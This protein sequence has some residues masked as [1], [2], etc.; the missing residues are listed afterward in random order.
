MVFGIQTSVD[1]FRAT[2]PASSKHA[3]KSTQLFD[4]SES[5]KAHE[6]RLWRF[7][8]EKEPELILDSNVLDS[9]LS[10]S[11]EHVDAGS[12]YQIS[13]HAQISQ[14]FA[15]DLTVMF[16]KTVK[17]GDIDRQ[18][19]TALR[20]LPTF[21]SFCESEM[22]REYVDEKV[23]AQL[24]QDLLTDNNT[25]FQY[26]R[27]SIK[28][29]QTD[30]KTLS[31][32]LLFFQDCHGLLFRKTLSW[33]RSERKQLLSGKIKAVRSIRTLLDGITLANR[34]Q[35][36]QLLEE[37]EAQ[38]E[39]FEKRDLLQLRD[40]MTKTKAGSR[41]S[42][43]STM[44]ALINQLLDR[45][46]RD[47]TSR[48]PIEIFLR[49]SKISVSAFWPK[50]RETLENGLGNPEVYLDNRLQV[51]DGTEA[52]NEQV[53]RPIHGNP[54]CM[55]YQ[56]LQESGALVNV[57]DWWEAFKALLEDSELEDQHM[58][59]LFQRGLAELQFLGLIR[60]S[61]RKADH[62]H[63]TTWAGIA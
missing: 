52:I 42:I 43:D 1:N 46:S 18:V 25:L 9:A 61:R 22:N 33:D 26:T 35:L 5:Q 37:F 44:K 54:T 45:M 10:A 23:S 62:V 3:L 28:R 12:E 50:P 57:S 20:Y 60:P 36:D 41:G 2:L 15:N 47:L 21:R 31:D 53:S 40:Q 59:A 48:Y 16:S 24:A 63:R 11:A 58:M 19:Y 51:S 6:Q 38:K 30:L 14:L 29:L 4:L 39:L 32:T 8:S 27:G 13:R 49:D 55:M 17:A 56:L 7:I 34:E